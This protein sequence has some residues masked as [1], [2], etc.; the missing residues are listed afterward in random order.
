MSF[1][2]MVGRG[3]LVNDIGLDSASS[4]AWTLD[5]ASMRVSGA[6]IPA[7]DPMW[8]AAIAPVRLPA[9]AMR[10]ERIFS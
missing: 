6:E 1:V 8:L 9:S 10:L 4:R 3:G 7:L 2:L 5:R